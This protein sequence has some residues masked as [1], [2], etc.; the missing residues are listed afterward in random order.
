MAGHETEL[1][2]ERVFALREAIARAGE[3]F[4]EFRSGTGTGAASP[5]WDAVVLTSATE[6]QAAAAG[7]ELD[8]RR[9]LGLFPPGCA[10]LAVADPPSGRVGS[11]GA[12]LLALERLAA[13][14]L[15]GTSP[16]RTSGAVADLFRTRRVLL[17]HSGGESQRLPAY[18]VLGKIFAPL[19]VLLPQAAGSAIFD[20]LY[21]LASAM[22]GA[23]GELTVLSGDVLPI[24]NPVFN[25]VHL[26]LPTAAPLP[27]RGVALPVPATMGQR[28]GVYV[29]DDTGAARRILQKPTLAQM[30]AAGAVDA[31]GQVAVDT[32]I[33]TVRLPALNA[34]LDAAGL[35]A[36]GGHLVRAG[37]LLLPSG[38]GAAP[39]DLYRD[40]LP[41]LA[42]EQ[43]T[44]PESAS[45]VERRLADATAGLAAGVAMP[46]EGVFIHLGTSRDFHDAVVGNS[47]LRHLF[48]FTSQRDSA[49][50][51][52]AEISGA[53]AGRSLLSRPTRLSRGA[54]V[55]HCRAAGVLDVGQ[56]AMASGV[57]VP[58]GETLRVAPGRLCYQTL[59]AAPHHPPTPSPTRREGE[60]QPGWRR[61][62]SPRVGEG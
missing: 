1:N 45:D 48:P 4:A 26:P 23:A 3:A 13:R 5:P 34:L 44:L 47:P 35:A 31:T 33:V 40:W 51:S 46:P 18:A 22:P 60:P 20:W 14:W 53:F 9:A 28:F 21:L 52:G 24:F 15:G 41:H 42:A 59:L 62:P 49:I 16:D 58:V 36:H 39:W 56:D 61:L 25:P 57:D 32:G 30:D 17:I 37:S 38:G 29:P 19:P 12:T 2:G 8:R 55:D 6:S 54:V 7:E 11:G 50:Q 27:V 43:D 10:L